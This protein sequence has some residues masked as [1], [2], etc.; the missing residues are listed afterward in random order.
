MK[1]RYPID[2]VWCEAR[3]L[4]TSREFSFR[5]NGNKLM[6]VIRADGKHRV[7]TVRFACSDPRVGCVLYK[8]YVHSTAETSS[9]LA[10]KR[11]ASASITEASRAHRTSPWD[12]LYAGHSRYLASLPCLRRTVHAHAEAMPAA[13]EETVDGGA[14]TVEELRKFL[15]SASRCCAAT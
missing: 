2:D 11:N 15:R 14:P 9:L 12:A 8:M 5:R 4:P 6:L 13:G 3:R 1:V 10:Q 7:K